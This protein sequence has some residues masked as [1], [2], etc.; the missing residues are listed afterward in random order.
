MDTPNERNASF[1]S[2]VEASNNI[3]YEDEYVQ[4]GRYYENDRLDEDL[5]QGEPSD[6]IDFQYDI[7]VN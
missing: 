7:Y 6:D 5:G 3:S 4:S 1:L 2:R